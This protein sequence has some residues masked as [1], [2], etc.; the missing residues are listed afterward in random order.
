MTTATPALSSATTSTNTTN[1]SI[2]DGY[3]L[4]LIREEIA[5]S[6]KLS[7]QAALAEVELQQGDIE[8]K[9][10]YAH[11]RFVEPMLDYILD[12]FEH[13]RGA[14][15]GSTIGGMVICD[16]SDQAREMFKI[17]QARMDPNI[18]KQL[19]TEDEDALDE[20]PMVADPTLFY[21]NRQREANKVKRC[22]LILHD[23]GS[24]ED[25]KRWVEEFKAGKIDLLLVYNSA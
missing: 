10:I 4:R 14:L 1:V 3:T 7:L 22:A 23:E 5:T 19:S 2:A 21:A 18:V 20:L 17:F 13:S 11:P 8:K 24:K 12:D 25:R 6:Y 16:S 9:W 15:N